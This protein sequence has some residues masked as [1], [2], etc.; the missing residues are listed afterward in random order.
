MAGIGID[1]AAFPV[2]MEA[3][4]HAVF[5]REGAHVVAAVVQ[6]HRAAV[7]QP[8]GRAEGSGSALLVIALRGGVI[9]GQ[10]RRRE[11]E[12]RFLGTCDRIAVQVHGHG[13]ACREAHAL[14]DVRLQVYRLS[15]LRRVHRGH[16]GGIVV[17]ITVR[18]FTVEDKRNAGLG[19]LRRR[20]AVIPARRRLLVVRLREDGRLVDHL[21]QFS[22]VVVTPDLIVQPGHV[23]RRQDRDP[24]VVTQKQVVSGIDCRV[25][26]DLDIVAQGQGGIAVGSFEIDT[27]AEGPFVSGDGAAG[28]GGRSDTG[29]SQ[30]A[31]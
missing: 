12:R 26:I 3:G 28:D 30:S 5:Q 14:F 4:D 25:V 13:L 8:F 2:G 24:R 21:I 29:N 1:R 20:E 22:G 31:A 17:G 7:L 23:G 10:V 16:Q 9:Q 6:V 18:G 27:A 11:I 15:F 19:L